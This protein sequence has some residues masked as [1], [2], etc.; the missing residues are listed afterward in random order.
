MQSRLR[1][2]NETA[3]PPPPTVA[4][5]NVFGP[6]LAFPHSSSDAQTR[7][8]VFRLAVFPPKST[9]LVRGRV[10]ECLRNTRV[11]SCRIEKEKERVCDRDG[12]ERGK[13]HNEYEGHIIKCPFRNHRD[14]VGGKSSTL[15]GWEAARRLLLPLLPQ[16]CIRLP[17]VEAGNRGSNIICSL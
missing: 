16:H 14:P 1:T 13:Y 11:A 10:A 9:N 3:G 17:A 7:L 4:C 5:M 2:G 8:H 12:R 6:N 15:L